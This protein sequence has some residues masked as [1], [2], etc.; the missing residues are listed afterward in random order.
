MY[1]FVSCLLRDSENEEFTFPSGDSCII[2]RSI[3]AI[4]LKIELPRLKFIYSHLSRIQISKYM[5]KFLLS[6]MSAFFLFLRQMLNLTECSCTGVIREEACESLV[7][8]SFLL[9]LAL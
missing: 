8:A 4:E 1:F 5:C 3:R 6:P 9:N 7:L 2:L